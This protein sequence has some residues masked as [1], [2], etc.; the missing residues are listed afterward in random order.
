MATLAP[1]R[2][3]HD[4]SLAALNTFGL[5]VRAARYYRATSVD[6]VQQVLRNEQPALV[7][8][9]GSN[10]L[11]VNDIEGL[12]LHVAIRGRDLVGEGSTPDEVI[13]EAGAGEPWHEFVLWTLAQDLGGLENLS[14]IPGYVGASPIQNIGAY[15][16]EVKDHFESLRAVNRDTG[17][18]ETFDLKACMFGYR[19]SAFKRALRDRY[20][21]THVR[22][23]LSA[24]QQCH[25]L[26]YGDIRALLE[27]SGQPVSPRAISEAVQQIRRSKLPDPAV[28]GNGGSFFKN[29]ELTAEQFDALKARRP[30]VRYYEL[31]DGRYKLPAAWLI[32]QAGWKGYRRDNI[33]VHDRQAL[34]LVNHGGGRGREV[35][36][37]AQEIQADVFE[38]FGVRIEPE[39]NVV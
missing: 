10:L 19:D 8:G 29:P 4:V 27:E 20:V 26:E 9:G 36:A 39:I 23:R 6:S 28:I 16:V 13:V 21:I 14:L 37:L 1:D 3:H 17:E 35:W 30:D 24:K 32:D 12:V 38:K 11:L 18:V 2:L 34:V 31:P 22:F 5:D 33:G 7:L 25:R 15:G